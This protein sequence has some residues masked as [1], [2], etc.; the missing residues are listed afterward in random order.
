MPIAA[1]SSATPANSP[2]SQVMNRL[3]EMDDA[4]RSSSV[5]ISSIGTFALIARTSSLIAAMTL[6]VS[7]PAVRTASVERC[8]GKRSN[9]VYILIRPNASDP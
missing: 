5:A 8:N 9:G 7:T 2:S 6:E 4:S 3:G 1:N